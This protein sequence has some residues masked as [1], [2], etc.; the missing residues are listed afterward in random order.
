MRLLSTLAVAATAAVT[1]TLVAAAPTAAASGPSF[2]A[3]IGGQ[4]GGQ[5]CR[6][7]VPSARKATRDIKSAIPGDL[8]D[9]PAVGPVIRDYLSTLMNNWRTAGTG[10][11]ADS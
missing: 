7:T 10:M 2:C 5:D 9:H 1:A 6:A 3:D 4:W 8:V 11:V